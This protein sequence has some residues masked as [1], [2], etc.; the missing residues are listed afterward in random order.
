MPWECMNCGNF[1]DDLVEDEC[2]KCDLDKFTAMNMEVK[3]R[4]NQCPE[5]GHAHRWSVA[6][7]AYTEA[8]VDE[9]EEEEEEAEEAEEEGDDDDGEGD[10]LGTKVKS[11]E[12][13]FAKKVEE[14]PD[15]LPTPA[16]VQKIGYIRCNCKLGVP[17]SKRYNRLPPKLIVGNIRVK[18]FVEVLADLASAGEKKQG[19]L[20]SK[21]EEAAIE[22]FKEMKRKDRFTLMI[23]MWLAF[24]APGS[25]NGMAMA[26]RNFSA[27]T[28]AYEPYFDMRNMVPWNVY[29]A[30]YQAVDSIYLPDDGVKAYTGGDKKINCS[31][32]HT[33]ETL[34]TI[35]RDSGKIAR[36]AY[37][38]GLIYAASANGSVRSYMLSHNPHKIKLQ[39][40][41][42]DHSKQVNAVMFALAS[43]GPCRMHGIIGHICYL[44][45]ISEDRYI[46]VWNLEKTRMAASITSMQLHRLSFRCMSQSGRHLF[47]GT[48]G[49]TV[50]VFSKFDTCERDDIHACN[51]PGT[52][53]A[54]CLQV[55]LK[56]PPMRMLSNNLTIV[57][58]LKCAGPNYSFSHLWAGDSSGQ[59]T[60]W[61]VPDEGLDFVPAKTWRAHKDVINAMETTWKHMISV[62]D[63]GNITLHDLGTLLV[64]RVI[65]VNIWCASIMLRPEI[66]RK[67]KCMHIAENYEEGGKMA[68]G[69]H[70]GEVMVIALGRE[71]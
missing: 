51:T 64:A 8:E 63:D 40:T 53:K 52:N 69:S 16:F 66:P 13:K 44:Y 19:K 65:P 22:H 14:A 21:E 20:K 71:V 24:L 11:T 60:V 37:M 68:V 55:S 57:T 2:I 31:N 39:K 33:G 15:E 30:H 27:A 54:Y 34:A 50:C 48:T 47:G 45:T 6:C 12:P 56:L 43:E 46:K 1:N 42:W 62:S 3:V 4:K 29:K 10:L 61:F 38:E 58:A 25:I 9:D 36:L 70:Y 59:I 17:L 5:C 41:Y 18:Q 67:L 28:L 49:S 26:N 35:T 23:P 7:H 32:S